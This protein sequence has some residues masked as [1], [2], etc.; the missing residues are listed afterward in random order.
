M[1]DKYYSEFDLNHEELY[2]ELERLKAENYHLK[3]QLS[4]KQNINRGQSKLIASLEKKLK[5]R[6]VDTQHYKNGRKRGG[7]GNGRNG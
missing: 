3:R 6:N 1:E 7:H 5:D 4:H 2:A